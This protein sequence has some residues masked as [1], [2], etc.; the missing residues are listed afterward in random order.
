MSTRELGVHGVVFVVAAG[1]AWRASVAPEVTHKPAEVELWKGKALDVKRIYYKGAKR[2]VELLPKS[3]SQG[4]YVLGSVT[5]TVDPPKQE[6]ATVDGGVSNLPVQAEPR[7]EK[8]LFVGVKDANELTDEIAS[9]RAA[10]ALGAVAPD[11]L[12]DFGLSG[13][14]TAT[15]VIELSSGT[16]TFT[17]GS[18]T[19]GGSDVYVQDKQ[20]QAVF[21]L[22]GA[23]T[24]DVE[25]AETRIMERELV[26][27][28]AGPLVNTVVLSHDGKTR[29][30]VRSKEHASF[31]TDES[32]P[33]EKNETLTNWMKKFE[34]LRINSYPAEQPQDAQVLVTADFRGPDGKPLGKIE[35]AQQ[36][37]APEDK[38]R[39]LARGA[40]T[41]LWGVV[42]TSSGSELAQDLPSIME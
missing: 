4:R 24:R 34:R 13:E 10:R 32:Q 21:V 3:D 7:V 28:D 20:S 31:W 11:K 36:M 16:H 5:K 2:E 26:A 41:R 37:V 30:I 19:P 14:D 6:P 25:L 22:N 33:N 12:A 39:F 1:I 38:P 17:V 8:E 15:L 42:L 35:L 23:T 18:R 40:Q 9:L 29:S 27:S